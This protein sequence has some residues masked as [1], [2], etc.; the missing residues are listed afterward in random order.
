MRSL[1]VCLLALCMVT[2]TMAAETSYIAVV[3]NDIHSNS[4]YLSQKYQQF[5]SD[6]IYLGVPVT[7]ETFNASSPIDQPEICDTSGT[8]AGT[9]PNQTFID[10]GNK[11]ALVQAG[12]SGS[13]EWTVNLPQKPL[14][15]IN[16]VMRCGILMPNA[17]ATSGYKAIKLFA[18]EMDQ[19][20]PT[21]EAIASP[22]PY[23]IPFT[24]FHLTAYRNPGTYNLTDDTFGVIYD[25][26]AMQ[27]LNGS[28]RTRILLKACM[29]KTIVTKLPVNGQK[30]SLG[31]TEAKL[32]LGDHIKVIMRVP[33]QNSVDIYC[34]VESLKVMGIRQSPF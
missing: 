24:P 30:N 6:Q 8:V 25:S 22:G 20:L 9:Y 21:I 2:P 10:N 13:Y 19:P 18:G 31:E 27:V 11:N 32:V 5:I 23:N 33:S 1:I 3:G 26:D 12:N 4:F 15:E 28:V 17:F 29:D 7:G 16:L 14:G 34:H